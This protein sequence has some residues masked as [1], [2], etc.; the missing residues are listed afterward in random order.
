M[1]IDLCLLHFISARVRRER[2]TFAGYQICRPILALRPRPGIDRL[3][4][5][6]GLRVLFRLAPVHAELLRSKSQL[7]ASRTL[8]AAPIHAAAKPNAGNQW[9]R[10]VLR[11]TKPD[12]SVSKRRF[13]CTG[14][15]V[16][17]TQTQVGADFSLSQMFCWFSCPEKLRFAF[18]S[19]RCPMIC[20]CR[21]VTPGSLTRLSLL[22]PLEKPHL[23]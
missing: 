18:V 4:T 7:P 2:K 1:K 6:T 8:P 3:A 15:G 21:P 9:S 20:S 14:S 17:N 22:G 11:E 23:D 5:R 16:R 19:T 10:A 12:E 13:G